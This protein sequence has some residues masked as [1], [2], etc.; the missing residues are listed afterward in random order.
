MGVIKK[1]IFLYYLCKKYRCTNFCKRKL[2]RVDLLS[3]MEPPPLISK[4]TIPPPPHNHPTTTQSPPTLFDSDEGNKMSSSKPQN[5][6]LTPHIN[7]H[8]QVAALDGNLSTVPWT[9]A[10]T[11]W[12]D[13]ETLGV[14]ETGGRKRKIGREIDDL[15]SKPKFLKIEGYLEYFVEK[16]M[17]GINM[18]G[19]R[20]F[21]KCVCHLG[22]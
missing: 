6:D 7:P 8:T 15:G 12:N 14:W 11:Y 19:H 18:W 13:T 20:G 10:A 4:S 17:S 3:P 22:H 5:T 21:R 16:S 1:L 2:T 9:C